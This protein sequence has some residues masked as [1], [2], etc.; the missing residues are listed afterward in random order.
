MYLYVD[1]ER[2][3]RL[4]KRYLAIFAILFIIDLRYKAKTRQVGKQ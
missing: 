2:K 4:T 3:D 1:S